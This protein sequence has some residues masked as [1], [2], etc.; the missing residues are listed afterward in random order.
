MREDYNEV[1]RITVETPPVTL[2]AD[3]NAENYPKIGHIVDAFWNAC[4]AACEAT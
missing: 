3:D 1:W 4:A 2:R